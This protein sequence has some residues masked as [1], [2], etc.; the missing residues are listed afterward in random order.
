[1]TP[2][3]RAWMMAY[4]DTPSIDWCTVGPT[5]PQPDDDGTLIALFDQA[6]IDAMQAEI[7]RLR[8]DRNREKRIR[9]DAEAAREDL[10]VEV[11]RLNALATCGCGDGFTAH[12]PGT[13]VACLASRSPT[14]S[15][16]DSAVAAERERWRA[17][18]MALRD[19]TAQAQ[20]S[21]G[22][23]GLLT[24]DQECAWLALN[25]EMKP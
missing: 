6:A 15:E 20:A 22:A 11:A 12:D 14:T 24:Y 4:G 13:C 7:A 1:M 21:P 16:I 10:I 5:E 3:P 18:V 9:K 8:D 2:K 23:F 19:A 17:L 25:A